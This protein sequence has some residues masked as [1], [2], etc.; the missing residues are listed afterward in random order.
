MLTTSSDHSFFSNAFLYS[1]LPNGPGN[2]SGYKVNTFTFHIYFFLGS[3]FF[4]STFGAA[5]LAGTSFP[6]DSKKTSKLLGF[7]EPMENSMDAVSDRD[8]VFD[9]LSLASIAMVHLSRLSEEIILW[10]SPGFGF[11][12]LLKWRFTPSTST[13]LEDSYN[14][15]FDNSPHLIIMNSGNHNYEAKEYLPSHTVPFI[16]SQ[17]FLDADLDGDLDIVIIEDKFSE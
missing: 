14:T 12:D 10:S 11:V 2:S 13:S 1:P 7:R 4:G 16:H 8:F 9:S 17:G 3:S 5:A 6:I 15:E